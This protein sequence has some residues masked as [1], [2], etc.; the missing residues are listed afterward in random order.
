MD[1]SD[2]D[3]DY[4][5]DFKVVTCDDP[6]CS[7]MS[8][9]AMGHYVCADHCCCLRDDFTYDILRCPCCKDFVRGRLQGVTNVKAL[10][11]AGKELERHV[12][13]LRRFC[14]G[15]G[16]QV[17][18]KFTKFVTDLRLKLRRKS[19]D[20]DF[21]RDLVVGDSTNTR[22][23][24]LSEPKSSSISKPSS[25]KKDERQ[26]MSRA[27]K[28]KEEEMAQLKGQLASMQEA[29][30]KLSP[31]PALVASTPSHS[32]RKSSSE[33][34][35]KKEKEPRKE[36]KTQMLSESE[37]E[38]L[39]YDMDVLRGRE[40]GRKKRRILSSDVSSVRGE[41]SVLGRVD[42]ILA[43]VCQIILSRSPCIGVNLGFRLGSPRAG[44]PVTSLCWT[45]AGVWW[46][47]NE[48]DVDLLT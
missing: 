28:A 34:G 9:N 45:A 4:A 20:L 43:V 31:S 24:D 5:D 46:N 11:A 40:S 21:F 23:D 32:G 48:T 6:D 33:L 2:D 7:R 41:K 22:D 25:S 39:A 1:Y 17:T 13:K 12:D 15:L 26:E 16:S 8:G 3:D 36:S 14:S 10:K 18:L 27:D 47:L 30:R 44:R 19:L 29:L 35:D 38:S 37:Y 42:Q